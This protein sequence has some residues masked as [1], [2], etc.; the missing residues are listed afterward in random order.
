MNG[1]LSISGSNGVRLGRDHTQA[2]MS[3]LTDLLSG[4]I[5]M[6]QFRE[7]HEAIPKKQS[8]TMLVNDKCNLSCRHCY[9]QTDGLSR[10][11]LNVG[12][13][14]TIIDSAAEH[15][16]SL[17]VLAGKEPLTGSVGPCLVEHLGD[18]RRQT[19]IRTGMITNGTLLDRHQTRIENANFSYID[20]SMEGDHVDNDAIR[21]EGAFA[22]ARPN[23][24]W[25]TRLLD[26]RLFITMTLQKE[27]IVRFPSAIEAFGQL[28]VKSVGAS[29]YIPLPYTDS[30]LALSQGQLQSFFHGL[31]ALGQLTL[32][33]DMCVQIDVGTLA[34]DTLVAFM[35]SDWFDMD[36]MEVDLS[37]FLYAGYRF[38]NGLSLHFRFV[39]WPLSI[40]SSCRISLDGHLLAVEDS[41]QPRLYGRHT[42]CNVRDFDFDFSTSYQHALTNLRLRA[43]DATYEKEVLPRLRKAYRASNS[44][45]THRRQA[46]TA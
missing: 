23:V 40:S 14:T 10:T 5:E 44:R 6:S 13:W 45:S 37:G 18:L 24:E 28:G 21:G 9:L 26:E 42:L 3:A 33:H 1:A 4:R 19:D 16:V 43:I 22:A 46:I 15:G 30:A 2:A 29:S 36:S 25:A 38:C 20:I 17:F 41:L 32:D 11:Q 12:E 35:E 7:R 34:P 27:N 31:D 39:P 8:L